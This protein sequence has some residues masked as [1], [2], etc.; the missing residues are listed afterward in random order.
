MVR[1][2]AEQVTALQVGQKVNLC[3]E[4]DGSQRVVCTVARRQGGTKFLTY[5]DKGQL[6]QF[7]IRDYPGRFYRRAESE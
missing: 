1:L 4:G 2:S 7:A 5:R 6:K 3:P